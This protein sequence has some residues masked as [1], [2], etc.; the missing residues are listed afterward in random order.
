MTTVFT[1][2]TTATGASNQNAPLTSAQVDANFINLNNDK[3]AYIVTGT[4]LQYW[5]GDK[6][7]Q[8]LDSTAVGLGAVNNTS[9]AAK[10]ISTA[11]QNALNLKAPLTG[12]GASGTWGINITGNAATAT[13]VAYS[14]LTGTVPTWNQNTTGNA[15][16]ASAVA[17]ANVT[18]KPAVIAAGVD[19]AT[20]RAAIGAGI[21]NLALG[22]TGSTALAGNTPYQVP[23]VSGITIKSINGI[24]ILG[25]GDLLIGSGGIEQ[26]ILNSASTLVPED[27]GKLINCSGTFTLSVTAAATL[28]SGWW[29]YVRNT[30]TGTVTLDP[31]GA[32]TVDGVISGLVS[33]TVL[34]ICNGTAFTASKLGPMTTTQVLTSGTSWTCPLGVRSIR[35][36]AVGGGGGGGQSSAADIVAPGGGGGGYFEGT[37]QTSPGTAYG[38]GIGAGGYASYTEGMGGGAGGNTYFSI[39]T[40]TAYAYGGSPG[41]GNINASIASGGDA[42]DAPIKLSGA[43]GFSSTKATGAAAVSVGGSSMLGVGSCTAGLGN[44]GSYPTGY[45][46]GGAGG[47]KAT[48]V[49]AGSPGVIILEY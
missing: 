5:R 33:G 48:G 31:N 39:A 28:G 19:Q 10:P 37:Y 29:C 17:W 12:L 23:L 18:S 27:L 24:S 20:A 40:P 25:S 43:A 47:F 35:A 30:G 38:Y 2:T 32:E 15:A 6:S 21:S 4:T 8:T 26:R 22:T 36:R 1:R 44:Q 7:W 16:T 45:G 46:G 9:D 11:T 14:G 42:A 13:N 3:E 49:K 41:S 34:V